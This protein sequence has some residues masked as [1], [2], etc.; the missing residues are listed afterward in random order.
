MATCTGPPDFL[1]PG[2]PTVLI[3]ETRPGGGGGGGGAASAQATAATIGAATSAAMAGTEPEPREEEDHF[4]HVK[5]VDSAGQ[6]LSG[7]HYSVHGPQDMNMG[8]TLSS[9]IKRTGVPE[10]E[11]E[12]A[13]RAI[14][15]AYWS[16]REARED[17]PVEMLVEA[18]GFDDGTP[19][20]IQVWER[21]INAPDR[22][23]QTIGGLALENGRLR[24]RWKPPFGQ[25]EDEQEPPKGFRAPSYFFSVGLE[26]FNERSGVLVYRDWVEIELLDENGKPMADEAFKA[27]LANGTIVIGQLNIS[28]KARIENI[29]PGRVEIS[30]PRYREGS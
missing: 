7:P 25:E 9:E 4:L 22:V 21:S 24:H 2:C 27:V 18:V 30:F 14:T 1:G 5:F 20:T 6:P 26:G 3:G 15:A 16:V 12:I 10:G 29:L 23:I 17:T 11:Y 28:G 19:V 8:G 13:I